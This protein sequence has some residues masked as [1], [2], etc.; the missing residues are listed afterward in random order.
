MSTSKTKTVTKAA[1]ARR[2]ALLAGAARAAWWLFLAVFLFVYGSDMAVVVSHP[3]AA[4]EVLAGRE[5]DLAALT[6]ALGSLGWSAPA[7]LLLYLLPEILATAAFL[8][9]GLLI[10][11]RRAGD[12]FTWFTSL[13]M[14]VFGVTSP[15]TFAL[16]G[17]DSSLVL[18]YN[19]PILFS[20][21]GIVLFLFVFP[22]GKFNPPWTRFLAIA[23][24]L[25]TISTVV[26]PWFDW[27]SSASALVILP[28]LVVVLY[29]YI[30]RYRRVFTPA[31]KEQTK[32]LIGAIVANIVL[33]TLSG[34]FSTLAAGSGSADPVIYV[35][36]ANAADFIGN[37]LLVAAVGI[38]ILRYRLWDIDVV[39]NR[40]LIYGPLSVILAA[41]FAV[42]VALINQST[43]Q[44]LGTEATVTATAVSALVVAT[45]F[46][47]I[48][49]RIEGWINKRVY[50]D[51]ANLARELVEISDPR[52]MLPA[53]ALAQKVAERIS[54]LV[55]SEQGAVYLEQ[56][57]GFRLAASAGPRGK[58]PAAFKLNAKARHDLAAGKIVTEGPAH[59][60]VPLYVPRLRTKELVGVLALG[61]RKNGRGYSSDDKRA[62]VEL[63]GQVGTALYAAQL[64]AK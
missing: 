53:P 32:W 18:L 6:A 12:W 10:G 15:S 58:L 39:V 42:T 22:D 40:A 19:V 5:F 14:I 20:Y 63:G 57:G 44:L 8:V 21:I 25:F 4:F 11:L 60:L 64:R 27:E 29:S 61:L 1:A 30:Y 54:K 7:F 52:I 47:P 50:A 3:Q 45:F 51:N 26:W 62:L 56:G 49:A 31:Q 17:L 43:R 37:L 28:L 16:S 55:N 23:W 36:L 2:Q 33:V 59:F 34:V 48:R 41:I 13:W 24:S 35:L 9:V 38:S 46:Q